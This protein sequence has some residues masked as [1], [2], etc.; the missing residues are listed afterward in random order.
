MLLTLRG[1]N[2]EVNIGRAALK[3]NF[4]RLEDGILKLILGGL[5]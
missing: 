1:R 4:H 5:Y 3:W 2:F